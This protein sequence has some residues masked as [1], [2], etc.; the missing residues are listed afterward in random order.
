MGLLAGKKA[1]IFGVANEK[2]IA[3]AIAEAF[4]REGA[5]LALTY[6]N[7]TVA[8]RVI[9]LAGEAGADLVL[10]CDVRSD[11]DIKAVFNEVDKAWGGMDILV[12]SIA[13]ANKEELKGSFLNTT[14]EGFAM[15]MDI[16]SY[17][18]IGLVK[19]AAPLMEG[20]EG[21]VL[22]M[23]YY[24]GQRVFP[25]YNVM[26]VAKAALE[27]SVRYLAEAVGPAGTRV[28]AISA[29]PLKTLA[30]AGVGGFNQI[31]GHV[32]EKAPLRRNITQED[33]AGAAV[34]LSSSL[35]RGVTGEIHFV[36]SGYNIIG[37]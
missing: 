11:A 22:A 16:S 33:V 8:K 1:V 25:S 31:A 10:P 26:G 15:A 34:Y 5:E 19:E 35:A 23:T 21:S 28:N 14:R 9:P 20:R 36:D 7:E 12:H 27:M 24:G 4:K 3:W 29:G 2:S 13:F 32:A 37:L 17:S 18:L 6:A 30:A